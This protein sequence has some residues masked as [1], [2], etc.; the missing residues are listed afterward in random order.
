MRSS[1]RRAVA[2][3]VAAVVAAAVAVTVAAVQEGHA[4]GFPVEVRD[5]AG[6]AVTLK[7]APQRVV[8]LAPSVT[9]TLFALGL[10]REVVGIS[11]ADDYPPER[12]RGRPRVGGVLLDFERIVALRPDLVIGMPSLQRDHLVRLRALGLPVLAVDASSVDETAALIRLLGRATG[13]IRRAEDLAESLE[14]RARALL[15]AGR[16]TVY[17]EVWGEPVLAAGSGT[18]VHDMTRWAGGVNIF[19]GRRG[20]V[21]V[22]LEAVLARDPQVIFLLYPGRERFLDRPGWRSLQ[23]ARAGRVHELATSLVARPG[24]RVAEGLTHIARLLWGR[25]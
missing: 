20:Y 23:A 19:E 25:P 12:V 2:A 1:A 18:L 8:S 22:P 6:A 9:E 11:D 24:P 14:R 16:R 4:S 5:A 21:Q 7:A 10:D 3:V 15:P 13:R 17:I